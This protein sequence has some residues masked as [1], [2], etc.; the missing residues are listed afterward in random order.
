MV[1]AVILGLLLAVPVIAL[2]VWNQEAL[3]ATLVIG[4]LLMGCPAIWWLDGF[5]KF[6]VTNPRCSKC[7]YDLTANTSGTCP[8]C[9]TAIP[10]KT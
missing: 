10:A 4:F 7:R 6:E 5:N 1:A 8:E 3:G 9:G 2:H